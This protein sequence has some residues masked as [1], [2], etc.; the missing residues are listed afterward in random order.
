MIIDKGE[1][2]RT[3]NPPGTAWGALNRLRQAYIEEEIQPYTPREVEFLQGE[4]AQAMDEVTRRAQEIERLFTLMVSQIEAKDFEQAD[5]QH[6][7]LIERAKELQAFV[8]EGSRRGRYASK[9]DCRTLSWR[10]LL[11]VNTNAKSMSKDIERLEAAFRRADLS[12]YERWVGYLLKGCRE[13]VSGIAHWKKRGFPVKDVWA[14]YSYGR[15]FQILAF[16]KAR[17]K[18][19]QAFNDASVYSQELK[20]RLEARRLV[21]RSVNSLKET[22]RQGNFSISRASSKISLPRPSPSAESHTALKHRLRVEKPRGLED[23]LSPGR[24]FLY[25]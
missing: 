21:P 9:Y 16:V 14:Q 11:K 2:T 12:S 8:A 23:V 7:N 25:A 6:F 4:I 24:G 5:A 18:A 15:K 19:E 10:K 3:V 17:I 1:D 20:E 13:M 22:E